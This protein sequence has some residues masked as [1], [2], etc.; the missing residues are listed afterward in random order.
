[1]RHR[2]FVP[3][4]DMPR[5]DRGRA[6]WL[7][8]TCRLCAILVLMRHLRQFVRRRWSGGFLAVYIAYSLAIQAMMASVGLGMSMSAVPYQVGFVL[9]SLGSQQTAPVPGSRAPAPAPQCPFCLVA[10]QSAGHFATTGEPPLLAAYVGAQIAA[11]SHPIDDRTIV[12]Q[13]R[14]THGEARAP[15]TFSA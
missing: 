13:L 8:P 3:A 2:A 15:P 11:I 7:S 12:L 14:H 1:M 10:A 4:I 6:N 5:I 9:C